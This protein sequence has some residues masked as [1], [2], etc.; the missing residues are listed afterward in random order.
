MEEEEDWF[1]EVSDRCPWKRGDINYCA[2]QSQEGIPACSK[3]MCA[4]FFM[5]A[6]IIS[7]YEDDKKDV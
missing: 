5:A 1:K 7:V 6:T 4:P 2:A 3:E